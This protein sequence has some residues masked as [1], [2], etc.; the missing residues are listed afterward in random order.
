[1]DD[2]QKKLQENNANIKVLG[3]G[4]GGVNSV[5]NMIRSGLQGVEFY[6]S[7]TDAQALNSSDATNQLQL[8]EEITRGL[9]AGADPI[10]R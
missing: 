7:N 4:G 1:M 9:G 6:A 10:H 8:G 5:N 2:T 3:I